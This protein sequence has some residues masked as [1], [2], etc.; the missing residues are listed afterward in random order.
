MPTLGAATQSNPMADGVLSPAYRTRQATQS[1][2]H[3]RH[4]QAARRGLLS[5]ENR[6]PFVPFLNPYPIGDLE[7]QSC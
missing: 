7:T 4:A 3:R 6:R 2:A 1:R 5:R